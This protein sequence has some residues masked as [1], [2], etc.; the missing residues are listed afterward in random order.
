[1]SSSRKTPRLEEM[2]RHRFRNIRT[3]ELGSVKRCEICGVMCKLIDGRLQYFSPVE[4]LGTG[5]HSC[6]VSFRALGHST[7]SYAH[8]NLDISEKG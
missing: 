4:G 2:D 5:L 3:A 7:H 8:I 6:P 1:M